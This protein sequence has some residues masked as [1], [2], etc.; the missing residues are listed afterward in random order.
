MV[1][2]EVVLN[3]PRWA[4]SVVKLWFMA[5]R[6]QPSREAVRHPFLLLSR[7]NDGPTA[8]DAAPSQ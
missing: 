2:Y 8:T 7:R 5:P 3:T 4:R 1:M 6:N